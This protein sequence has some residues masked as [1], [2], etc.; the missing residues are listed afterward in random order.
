M[1]AVNSI[2][3]PLFDAVFAVLGVFSPAAA[4]LVFSASAGVVMMVI[5]RHTSSQS[6][7]K[8]VADRTRAGLLAM[9]LFK[10]DLNVALR[11]LWDMFKASGMRLLYSLPPL[12]VLVVP[13][14][15]ILSQLGA[16]YEYRPLKVGE[17]ARVE[18]RVAADVW[19]AARNVVLE[20][21]DAVAVETP[22]VRD[23]HDHTI[24][25][26]VRPR[27]GG[28]HTL[29]WRIGDRVI[30][31]RL[32]VDDGSSGLQAISVMRPGSSLWDR[33]LHPA[34]PA[35]DD[36]SGVRSITLYYDWARSTPLFG[37]DVHWLVTFLVGSIVFGLLARPVLKVQI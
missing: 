13:F 30:E 34:E 3:N 14:A 8:A 35:L 29:T 7:L 9:L 21:P 20:T 24:T 33:V 37:Y 22:G 6:A 11:S 27:A 19:D 15:L 4:L 16:R 32:A 36:G 31:K 25:W 26:R 1:N 18:L 28:M 5:F 10:D 17:D 23:A 2:M 12:L